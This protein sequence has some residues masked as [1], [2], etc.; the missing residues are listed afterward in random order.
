MF[1]ISFNTLSQ[2][3]LTY[4]SG[5]PDGFFSSH[6]SLK[7]LFFKAVAEVAYVA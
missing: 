4:G 2:N 7:W 3:I 6:I 1:Y 5:L